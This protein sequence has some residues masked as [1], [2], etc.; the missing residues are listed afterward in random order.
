M[1]GGRRLFRQVKAVEAAFPER[2]RGVAPAGPPQN[3]SMAAT[4]PSHP[5][6]TEQGCVA[7]RVADALPVCLCE[8]VVEIPVVRCR[9]HRDH[10][11][12]AGVAGAPHEVGKRAGALAAASRWVWVSTRVTVGGDWAPAQSLDSRGH[13]SRPGFEFGGPL[14]ASSAP[15][16]D[17]PQRH[18]PARVPRQ[19]RDPARDRLARREG[20]ALG[21]PRPER[22]REDV[23]PQ[24]DHGLP[25]AFLGRDR[26]P[27]DDLRPRRLARSAAQGRDRDER[28]AGADPARGSH[29]GHRGE[30][31]ATRSWTCGRIRDPPGNRRRPAPC[32]G[33]RAA[34][35][36][37]GGTWTR[38]FSQ[39][40]R[41]RVLIARALMARTAPPHPGRAVRGPGPRRPRGIPP[42]PGRARGPAGRALSSSSSAW[43]H[44][45]E[46]MP[47]FTHALLIARDGLVF[48]SGPKARV[49]TT[50][51]PAGA[52]GAPVSVRRSRGRYVAAAGRKAGAGEPAKKR[53]G[54]AC[55]ISDI[56]IFLMRNEDFGPSFKK[57]LGRHPE[58]GPAFQAAKGP[59][60]PGRFSHNRGGARH[61]EVLSIAAERPASVARHA[62]CRYGWRGMTR[63]IG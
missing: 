19:D 38:I 46:I 40:E 11:L 45:E 4:A 59:A 44:A 27:R 56:S 33:S 26:R 29:A 20:R 41:Q 23:A 8:L 6:S 48:D 31:G 18:R 13:P 57:L 2:H 62:S 34:P 30:R 50:K 35:A 58:S 28:P 60:H 43:H 10:P 9:S 42:V 7:D 61:E 63:T 36:S 37:P 53:Q 54:K 49:V 3:R 32:P 17:I 24:V 1:L 15:M 14:S 25:V 52:F 47:A 51:K 39:G 55:Y 12:D 16:A 22:L 21:H 5:S